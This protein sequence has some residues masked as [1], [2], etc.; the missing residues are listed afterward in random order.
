MAL[1]V[2]RPDGY[3]FYWVT[4]DVFGACMCIVFLSII[5]INS[6]QVATIL[7]IVAFFY[8]I[9]FVFITPYLFKGE[10]IM[11]TVATSGGPPKKDPL[12]CEKYP[13]DEGCQGGDP[14]PMLFAIPRLFDYQG[15]SSL[16]GLGDIV[17]TFSSWMPC[18][19]QLGFSTHSFSLLSFSVPGLLLSF[20]A[21]FDAA[22]ALVGIS[23]GGNQDRRQGSAVLECTGNGGPFGS[24][25]RGSY[26][27]PLVIAYA[28]GLMMA[29]VA[30]YV[31]EMGQ[32]ALLYLVPC[33]LGTM[34]YLGWKRLEL[35]A[36]WEGPKMLQLADS[37]V[38]G[39]PRPSSSSSSPS[40]DPSQIPMESIGSAQRDNMSGGGIERALDATLVNSNSE[41]LADDEA[42]PLLAKKSID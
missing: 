28:I 12:W 21:R 32:P 4:Q 33:T 22:K 23:S 6:I 30:V 31:M 38:Y 11:V 16:L 13:A 29:N 17:C 3:L 10:S 37:I 2:R 27:V 20:A 5:E 25:A 7:L 9:F 18:L 36:L 8:D 34:S 40:N 14:L 19:M 42:G 26:F 15:G 1:F 24:V 41:A 35:R 39:T